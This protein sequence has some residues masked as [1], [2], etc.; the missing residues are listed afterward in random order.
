MIAPET[1]TEVYHGLHYKVYKD[2]KRTIKIA[3][4]RTDAP[5]MIEVIVN[6]RMGNRTRVKCSPTDT[7]K[8]LKKLISA[9]TG[10][11][12]DKIRLQRWH[13]IFKDHITLQDYE[14]NHGGSIDMYY[15]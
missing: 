2:H 8:D 6:D 15:N 1:Y 5:V 14:I 7:I 10:T 11:R 4:N 3:E 9:H 12:A 13:S